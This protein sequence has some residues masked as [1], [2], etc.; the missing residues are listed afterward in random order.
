[1]NTIKGMTY[2]EVIEA[3]E[4]AEGREVFTEY[5]NEVLAYELQELYEIKEQFDQMHLDDPR[6]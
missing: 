5:E 4:D 2:P 1:M 6:G 3:I